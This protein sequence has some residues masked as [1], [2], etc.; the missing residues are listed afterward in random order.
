[1]NC[2]KLLFITFAFFF[3]IS[4]G[5]FGVVGDNWSATLI[6]N[7]MVAAHTKFATDLNFGTSQVKDRGEHPQGYGSSLP[8]ARQEYLHK[9]ILL[10]AES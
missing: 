10:N 9:L 2:I 7:F 1:M 3:Q 8:L 5:I 4:H 6:E